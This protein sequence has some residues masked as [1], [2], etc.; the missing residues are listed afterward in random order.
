M[1]KI[2]DFLATDNWEEYQRVQLYKKIGKKLE[3]EKPKKQGFGEAMAN[4]TMVLAQSRLK[5][6][7]EKERKNKRKSITYVNGKGEIVSIP[8]NKSKKNQKVYHLTKKELDI[9]IKNAR[10]KK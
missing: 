6:K 3:P 5:A 10:K 9:I 7:Q 2:W 4:L 1:G 8:I